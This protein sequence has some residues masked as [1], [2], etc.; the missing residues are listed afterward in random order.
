ME[1][2]IFVA[3]VAC[4]LLMRQI[5]TE[6]SEKDHFYFAVLFAFMAATC[7]L[8]ALLMAVQIVKG[9]L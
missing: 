8:G 3:M 6:A 1:H 7:A 2:A 5:L 4:F 9:V